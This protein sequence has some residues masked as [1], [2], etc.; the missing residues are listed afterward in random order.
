MVGA[1]QAFQ[2]EVL[3]ACGRSHGLSDVERAIEDMREAGPPTWSLDLISGLPH[4]TEAMW[5]HSLQEALAAQ[6]PHIS[7]YDL[8]VHSYLRA[9]L[10]KSCQ[11]CCQIIHIL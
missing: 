1:W 5:L 7:I 10:W 9:V 3:E 8:Q 11:L 4:L 6:P 2:Q